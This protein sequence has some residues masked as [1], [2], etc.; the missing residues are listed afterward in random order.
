MER[1]ARDNLEGIKSALPCFD[2]YV[3]IYYLVDQYKV[4]FNY[5]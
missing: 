3:C 5:Y 2:V 1:Y 4:L